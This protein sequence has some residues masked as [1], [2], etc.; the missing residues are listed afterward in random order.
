MRRSTNLSTV[1][2]VCVTSLCIVTGALPA[3]ADWSDNFDG[4]LQLG[5]LWQFGSVDGVGDPS[6]T[7]T[8]DSVNDQLVMTDTMSAATGG[9]GAGFGLV[10]DLLD[11]QRM[12]G[13]INPNGAAD[14]SATLTLLARGSF[15][16]GGQFYAAEVNY[17]SGELIIFRND[18][19][20]D[21]MNSGHG[22]RHQT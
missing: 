4:G 12:A 20:T 21:V 18:S 19:A 17:D 16:A 7:F 11:N 22:Y 14:I 1:L 6:A 3:R 10:L 9:A 5:A 15:T 13:V 8:A 2:V